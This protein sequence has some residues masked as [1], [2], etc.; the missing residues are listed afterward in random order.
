MAVW[1]S[2]KGLTQTWLKRDHSGARYEWVWLR[3]SD[4]LSQITT[5]QSGSSSMTRT[6]K[7]HKITHFLGWRKLRVHTGLAEVPGLV[8]SAHV[9][10]LTAI[11]NS[12]SMII[13]SL[14]GHLYSSTHMHKERERQ[15]KTDRQMDR[16]RHRHI[17]WKN[18]KSLTSS[19]L[20]KYIAEYIKLVTK[21]GRIQILGAV[22]VLDWWETWVSL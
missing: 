14:H 7:G 10:R 13:Q 4:W 17:I 19:I 8:L 18:N 15:T 3:N 11:R 12:S 21:V 1:P 22:L 9:G 16:N 20:F 6:K 2:K 5:F